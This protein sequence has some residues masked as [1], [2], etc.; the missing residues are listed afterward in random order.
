M[1]Y[2]KI[3]EE[4]RKIENVRKKTLMQKLISKLTLNKK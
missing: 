4:V 3:L 1:D 2:K